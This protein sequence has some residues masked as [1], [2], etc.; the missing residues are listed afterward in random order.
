MLINSPADG[1]L[2]TRA[3]LTRAFPRIGPVLSQYSDFYS[4]KHKSAYL[5][6]QVGLTSTGLEL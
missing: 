2:T 4:M 6:V 5:R 3:F 1:I